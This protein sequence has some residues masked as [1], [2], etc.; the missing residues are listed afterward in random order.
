MQGCLRAVE[1]AEALRGGRVA[2][3]SLIGAATV[4]IFG[5]G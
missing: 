2:L 4:T 3:T 1:R 5:S